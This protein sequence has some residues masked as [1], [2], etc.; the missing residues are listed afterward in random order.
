M[1]RI[2]LSEVRHVA[3]LARLTFEEREIEAFTRQL[4]DILEFVAQLEGLD[5]SGVEPTTRAI[6]IFN[7]F[8]RDEVKPSLSVEEALSNAPQGEGGAFVVPRII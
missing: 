4:N 8:R 5:T 7:V 1:A 2:T 6:E 3:H